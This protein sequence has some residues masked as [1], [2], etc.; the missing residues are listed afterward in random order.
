MFFDD[1]LLITG[2]FVNYLCNL[3]YPLDYSFWNNSAFLNII[4]ASVVW[5]KYI[6][7]PNKWNLD[8]FRNKSKVT[9]LWHNSL[10]YCLLIL[11]Y[12]QDKLK[13]LT[14]LGTYQLLFSVV[15]SLGFPLSGFVICFDGLPFPQC[16]SLCK[17]LH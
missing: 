1:R 8:Y 12:T 16:I 3:C 2:W 6:F 13:V 5:Y 10:F 11:K 4:K 14:N 7:L 15:S 9:C 17:Y